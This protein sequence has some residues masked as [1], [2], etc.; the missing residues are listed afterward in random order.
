[1]MAIDFP[2]NAYAGFSPAIATGTYSLRLQLLNPA[3]APLSEIGAMT[4][5]VNGNVRADLPP[6]TFFVN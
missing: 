6:I 2:C 4:F 1:M 3:G 5:P